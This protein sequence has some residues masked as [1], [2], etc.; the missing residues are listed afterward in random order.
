M[1]NIL[2]FQIL[3]TKIGYG[4]LLH[5]LLD[6]QIMYGT[7]GRFFNPVKSNVF[8]GGDHFYPTRKILVAFFHQVLKIFSCV[9]C[10]VR[11]IQFQVLNVGFYLSLFWMPAS[12]RV[13]FH[14]WQLPHECSK[15]VVACRS[16]YFDQSGWS[17]KSFLFEYTC[18]TNHTSQSSQI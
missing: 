3:S 7:T 1:L 4:L 10:F 6:Y 8:L 17:G 16:G 18:Q 13:I 15:R 14:S 12:E 9:F 2:H 11:N 5:V